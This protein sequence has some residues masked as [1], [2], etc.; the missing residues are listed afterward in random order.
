LGEATAGASGSKDVEYVEIGGGRASE[1]D[2][3]VEKNWIIS[4]M[5]IQ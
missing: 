4:H 2:V 5:E 3:A 1:M